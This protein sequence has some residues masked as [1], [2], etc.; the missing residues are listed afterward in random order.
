MVARG[1]DS[2]GLMDVAFRDAER[3]F[4]ASRVVL[5]A[6]QCFGDKEVSAFIDNACD[7]LQ[8][9]VVQSFGIKGAF[10]QL[11]NLVAVGGIDLVKFQTDEALWGII[12]QGIRKTTQRKLDGHFVV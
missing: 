10:K 2:V 3:E 4:K 8:S 6:R 1:F 9:L 11:E 12:E 7:R 5:L